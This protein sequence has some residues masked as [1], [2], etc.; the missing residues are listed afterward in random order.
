MGVR[1]LGLV[2]NMSYFVCLDT[3]TR[4]EIFGPTSAEVL[5]RT[6]DVPLLGRLPVDP[7]I[8]RLCDA[9]EIAAYNEEVAT[10]LARALREQV[11]A[12]KSVPVAK[13]G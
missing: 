13:I 10:T 12:H 4:H 7:Q 5:A 11:S 1:V 9:G 8:S 2:E 3:G 6:A